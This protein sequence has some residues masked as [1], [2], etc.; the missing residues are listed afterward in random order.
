MPRPGGASSSYLLEAGGVAVLLD[1]GPGSMA[2]LQLAIEYT[3]LDAIVIS[4]VHA[5]H[6]FDLVPLRQGLRHGPLSRADRLPLFLPPAGAA[7]LEA[8]QRAVSPDAPGDFF[9]AVYAVE[10]Y[11]P[12]R[13]LQIGGV[14]LRFARTRHYIEGYAIRAD[15][16]E[17]SV[18]YS[19]DTAPCDAVVDL[20]RQTSLFLCEAALGLDEESGER[21]HCSAEEAGEMAQRA[22][23]QRLVLTHYGSAYAPQRL[24]DAA[25][26]RFGGH[27][28]AAEDGLVFGLGG[29]AGERERDERV[30]RGEAAA[31]H[32]VGS[33][34]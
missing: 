4:H 1:A 12:A 9:D 3:R 24:V 33:H 28:E 6:F 20:A 22:E 30:H 18:T 27:T 29:V 25:K 5:D 13:P 19:S 31:D 7:S 21:G 15:A 17:A 32:G 8:L 23:A 16:G 26:R 34:A 10:E 14:S 2:K 11:D